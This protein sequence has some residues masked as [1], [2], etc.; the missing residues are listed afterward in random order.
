MAGD[1][2]S[3]TIEH[4][5]AVVPVADIAASAAWYEQLFG[6][7]P[8]NRPMPKLVEWQVTE[9]GWVQVFEDRDRAGR[10][11]VNF[12][13]EDLETHLDNLKSRGLSPGSIQDATKGVRIASIDDPDGNTVTFIGGFR[14][15]Y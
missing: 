2:Q 3:M 15:D 14:M 13:V 12:A 9:S 10:S 7:A 11:F 4:V 8:K 6:S 5:L 1:S